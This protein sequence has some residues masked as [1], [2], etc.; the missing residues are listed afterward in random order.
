LMGN[1]EDFT[2]VFRMVAEK[3]LKETE[4]LIKFHS[5]S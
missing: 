4:R 2:P 1:P 3:H 5:V